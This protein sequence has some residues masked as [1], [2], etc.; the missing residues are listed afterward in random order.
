LIDNLAIELHPKFGAASYPMHGDNAALLIRNAHVGMEI[1]PHGKQEVGF[2][3]PEYDIYSESRLTL[4]SDLKEALTTQQTELYYQPKA[5][6]NSG[7]IIGLEALIRWHHPER[8]WVYPS[9]FIPLAEETGVITQLTRWAIEKGIKDLA[10]LNQ[11]YPELS[12]SINISARDLSAGELSTMISD[13]LK[14]HQVRPEQLMLELT[15]TA[16]MEDPEQ[17]LQ[18]LKKL[19]DQGLSVSIDDFGSGYSSLSYLK[20]LPATEIKLDRSLVMDV[21]SDESSKV[22]VETAINMAHGLGYILVAEGVETE[23]SARLLKQMGCDRLQG[24][25]LCHPLPLDKLKQWMLDQQGKT[26]L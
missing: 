15:E 10:V 19:T 18:V 25:W 16:A 24:Y 11:D 3:S 7:R 8:G 1:T 6:L 17:G 9:D 13:I 23:A 22:I 21:C 5:C 2:Y 26:I 4:M 14:R 20:K 12:I